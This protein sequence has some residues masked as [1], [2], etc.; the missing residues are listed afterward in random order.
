MP[1][2]FDD[3]QMTGVSLRLAGVQ[4][5]AGGPARFFVQAF[6][7][8]DH[9]A[10]IESWTLGLESRGGA[11]SVA[12]LDVTGTMT[13]MYKVRIPAD[14]AVR[15]RR[16]EVRHADVRFT[17]TDAA[18]FYD[19]LPNVE[20]A[21]VIV[22]RG[23]VAFTPGDANE[24]HQLE[25]LYKKDR[26]EDEVESLFVRCAPGFFSANIVI[27]ADGTGAAVSAVERDKAAAV[28]ARNYPRS[29]TIES[30]IDG[31]LLSFLPQGD[32]AV[33]EFKARRFGEMVYIFYPFSNEEVSLYDHG[34]DRID[35]P[36][37]PGCRGRACGPAP[38]EDVPLVRGEVRRQ[39]LHPRPQPGPLL[40][41]PLGQGP[42]RGHPQGRPPRQPQVPVQSRPRD[43]QDHGRGRAGAVLHGGQGPL[44][45]LR[46]FRLAAGGADADVDRGHLPRPH[47]AGDPDDRRH[48]TGRERRQ[49]PHPAPLRDRLL[50]P[51]RELVPRPGRGGLL[52]GPPD[53]HGP[54]G[55]PLRRQ[56]R[57][58]GP[59]P[60]RGHGGRRRPRKGR[61][62]RLHVRLPRP[63][64]VPVVHR[65]KVPPQEG[66]ARAGAHLDPR[67]VG[68]PRFA[69]GPGRSGGRHPRLLRPGLR[70]LPVREA[71][72]RAAA[73]ARSRRPQPGLVHRPQ[74]GPLDRR[75]RL[76]D[77]AR[78]ARRPVRLG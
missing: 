47:G 64:E 50:F 15:A 48:R 17:F 59:G 25:L 69:A 68:D 31:E 5:D 34:K 2:F 24:K 74:R 10:L 14:R 65:R 20:T 46:L 18:V 40:I 27:E 43:P 26:I 75:F 13:R 45:P 41:L 52:P 3:L 71:G 38:E 67:R 42:D 28:F 19:N 76:P 33:F 58:G 32:E 21:L 60:A 37:Q 53:G 12:R 63:G 78:H 22:G 49:D 56:R 11:W 6:F 57:A 61:Q 29:Y 55:V 7:E 39:P 9:A 70:P 8:N 35:L 30:S 62:R 51:R 16:V 54:A 66:A 44:D 23:R 72:H 4:R 36:L 1:F 73:L 77:D